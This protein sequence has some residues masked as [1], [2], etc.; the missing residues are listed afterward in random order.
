MGSSVVT[1]GNL[2][3]LLYCLDVGATDDTSS[4]GVIWE[5]PVTNSTNY[6][7]AEVGFS[8]IDDHLSLAR[9]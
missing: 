6:I 2:L 9:P 7:N 5:R 1:S 4:A 8:G 3:V